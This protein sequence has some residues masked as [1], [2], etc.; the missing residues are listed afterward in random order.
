MIRKFNKLAAAPKSKP[1]EIIKLL[2]ISKGQ[3]IVEI[4]VGGGYFIERFA[5]LVGE[6]GSVY[7]VDTNMFFLHNLKGINKKYKKQVVY[8]IVGDREFPRMIP[9]NVDLIFS[10]NTYHHLENRTEYFGKLKE[11]L[12]ANGLLAIIDYNRKSLMGL[13]GHGTKKNVIIDELTKAGFVFKQDIT[14]I[15]KQN[16]ILFGV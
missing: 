12:S 15:K 1:D 5:E 10:R 4:G 7:G 16:F 2:N 13:L 11:K 8:P 9:Q 6:G 14:I 3:T